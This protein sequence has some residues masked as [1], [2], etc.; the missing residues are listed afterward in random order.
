MLDL[1]LR[2]CTLADGRSGLDIGIRDSRIVA[3]EPQLNAQ[4][5]ETLDAAGQLHQTRK[6][7]SRSRL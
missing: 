2:N 3:L 7:H 5:G 6:Q 4:A 1:V